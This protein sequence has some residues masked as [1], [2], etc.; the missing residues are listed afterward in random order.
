MPPMRIELL[1][2]ADPTAP[3]GLKGVGEPPHI[4]TP[5]AVV[6]ALRA[7]TGR[8]L[9][10]VPVRP[11]HIVRLDEDAFVARYGAL[12]EHSPWVARE[13]FRR[14]E[15]DLAAA[16]E[17]ALREAPRE[18]QLAVVRAHPE[19]AGR[20]A[21]AGELTEASASE[22]AR[23]GL[24][25]LSGEELADWRALNAAY[26]ERFGFPLVVCVREHT[27]ASILAWGRERL[28]ND[29]EPELAIAVGEVV[30]I[31]RLRLEDMR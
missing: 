13:A 1:E 10:R 23:A 8:P 11:E 29:P 6:A 9:T 3:Y 27:K 4:S 22:Q 12:F 7:A 2:H 31:A 17:A 30:K 5:P 14:R 24:D 25:R 28:G 20:E 21:R 16:F 15:A 19:L 26:R 18:K